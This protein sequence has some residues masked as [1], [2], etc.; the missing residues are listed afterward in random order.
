MTAHAV[1]ASIDLGTNTVL[2]LVARRA[3][4]GEVE[5]LAERAAI[6]RLGRGLRESGHLDPERAA[7]TLAVLC[8]YAAVARA[9]GA[10]AIDAVAT[11]ALRR[12][13]DAAAFLQRVRAEAGLT[14]RVIDG[15]EEARLS[16][17]AQAVDPSRR[18]EDGPLRVVDIGG[19]STEVALGR[20]ARLVHAV[21][22]EVGSVRLAE[23]VLA[24][25]PD[26]PGEAAREMMRA[27]AAE[28]LAAAA[29]PGDAAPLV[30][31]AGTA[32]TLAAMDLEMA[33]WDALR[34]HGYVLSRRRL[35]ELSGRLVG[36]TLAE[37]RVLPGV[38]PARADVLPAG[39]AIL[40]A[41]MDAF[42]AGDVRVSDRSLRWGLV[43]EA[44]GVVAGR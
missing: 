36:L 25:A 27:R 26:P 30:A 23:A 20:G 22:L 43:Y 12:A 40:E 17:L 7:Q 18:G 3:A 35:A 14:L 33:E 4:G 16:Y 29:P 31:V 28:V 32:T 8:E 5:P 24:A 9:C 6:T 41:V 37:R 13:S 11:S 2:L 44:F 42:G 39:A 15:G 21:S 1:R 34:V 38:E 19:G 10:T